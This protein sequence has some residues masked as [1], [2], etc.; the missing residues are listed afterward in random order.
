M[1]TWRVAP[2]MVP[3]QLAFSGVPWMGKNRGG[4]RLEESESLVP[5]EIGMWSPWALSW[6]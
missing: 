3:G 4:T 6:K 1:G 2:S 5:R